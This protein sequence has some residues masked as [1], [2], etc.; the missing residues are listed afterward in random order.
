MEDSTIILLLK[1][2]ASKGLFEATKKYGGLVKSISIKILHNHAEDVEECVADTFVSLWKNV[3]SIDFD[4]GT[5]K[6]YIACI[7]RNTAI[8]IYNK[9]KRE[10]TDYIENKDMI[11]DENIEEDM[12]RKS[13]I[14]VL[15]EILNNM[16]EPD[17][18]I[19]IRRFF[20]FEKIKSIADK[21]GLTEKIVEN[22]LFR[23][24]QKLKKQL[25]E[26]GVVV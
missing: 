14:V 21:L 25:I 16:G 13:D 24:K 10:H 3:N 12:A 20:Q 11:S 1:N 17:K 7:A 2:D 26:R 4:R 5:L 18:E 23:G 19:F 6:G 15:Q 22:K 8:N 9:L